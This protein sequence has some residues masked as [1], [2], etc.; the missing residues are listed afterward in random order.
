MRKQQRTRLIGFCLSMSLLTCCASEA[1]SEK[2]DSQTNIVYQVNQSKVYKI[3][4]PKSGY[5]GNLSAAAIEVFRHPTSEAHFNTC[6]V[7]VTVIAQREHIGKQRIVLR[8]DEVD[9][10]MK[11]IHQGVYYSYID[12]L[13]EGI[14]II[15]RREDDNSSFIDSITKYEIPF[16]FLCARPPQLGFTKGSCEGQRDKSG[17]GIKY[18]KKEKKDDTPGVNIEVDRFENY[19]GLEELGSRTA[20]WYKAEVDDVIKSKKTK[21][22]YKENQKWASGNDWL[23]DEME[24]F[25]K[26]GNILMKCKKIQ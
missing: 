8:L 13:S 7:N 18:L 5:I 22:L 19:E 17:L 25:D 23:W 10:N 3:M 26:D 11:L 21:M 14:K 20:K 4:V 2:Q 15:T 24:R 1:T 6:Y 16:P 9:G 12:F